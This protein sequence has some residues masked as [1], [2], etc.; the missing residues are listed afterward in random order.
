[1]G[2]DVELV[3]RARARA[4]LCGLPR[5]ILVREEDRHVANGLSEGLEGDCLLRLAGNGLSVRVT[6]VGPTSLKVDNILAR[7]DLLQVTDLVPNK[8]TSLGGAELLVEEGVEVGTEDI[9]GGAEGR[10]VLEPDIDRLGDGDLAIVA[11][12]LPRG[13]P[14]ANQLNNLSRSDGVAGDGLVFSNNVRDKVPLSPLGNI[15]DLLLLGAVGEDT[16]DHF[17]AM[18][19]AS[20][21][22][23]LEGV[24]LGV[25]NTNVGESL[26]LDGS[27]LLLDLGLRHAVV[28]ALE[29]SESHA[30]VVTT[31]TGGDTGGSRRGGAGGSSGGLSGSSGSGDSSV[32]GRSAGGLIAVGEGADVCVVGVGDSDGAARVGVGTGGVGGRGGVHNNGVGGHGGGGR[33]NGVSTSAGTD[34]GGGLDDAGDGAAARLDGGVGASDGRGSLDDGGDTTVGVGTAGELGAGG[35]AD[36]GRL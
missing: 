1:M 31:G 22:D 33:G 35:T 5:V 9:N 25:V 14:L 19:L 17:Q 15:I 12:S 24:A 29:E 20:I 2:L 8:L 21:T 30:H 13:P 26:L 7:A 10:A 23:F 4:L 18:G 28:V 11:G 27:D 16:E 34:V 32:G 3:A 6:V 36:S